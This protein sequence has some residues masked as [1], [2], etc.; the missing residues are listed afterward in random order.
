M[1]RG[2]LHFAWDLEQEIVWILG[3]FVLND[4]GEYHHFA[5][6]NSMKQQA[7]ELWTAYTNLQHEQWFATPSL[8]SSLRSPSLDSS[9]LMDSVW[10]CSHRIWKGIGH[11][12]RL[13]R[14]IADVWSTPIFFGLLVLMKELS[15]PNTPR[16]C[17]GSLPLANSPE[18]SSGFRWPVRTL[19]KGADWGLEGGDP[20]VDRKLNTQPCWRPYTYVYVFIHIIIQY[21]Q[22]HKVW[23]R[24]ALRI[25][26]PRVWDATW[27][28]V[29]LG[30]ASIV[31]PCKCSLIRI[32]KNIRKC[33]IYTYIYI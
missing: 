13:F 24:H 31:D 4:A 7:T 29:D 25:P 9:W 23:N 2:F 1:F 19:K 27:Y 6:K 3:C 28:I 18:I 8:A 10:F 26:Q 22:L 5:A 17:Y 15:E 20:V 16:V 21:P 11:G 32:A 12:S 14:V 30:P 33:Y